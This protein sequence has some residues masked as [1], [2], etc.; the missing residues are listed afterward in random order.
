MTMQRGRVTGGTTGDKQGEHNP[1]EHQEAA[2]LE[3]LPQCSTMSYLFPHRRILKLREVPPSDVHLT[4]FKESSSNPTPPSVAN[5][6]V[7]L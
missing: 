6:L 7:F 2:E 3:R 5:T 1:A 4:R